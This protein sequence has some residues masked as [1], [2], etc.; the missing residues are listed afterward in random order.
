MKIIKKI[1]LTLLSVVF[2]V[3]IAAGAVLY[4]V[5]EFEKVKSEPNEDA[6]N[7][8][9][10]VE[11]DKYISEIF[12]PGSHDSA[13]A[14]ISFPFISRCQ[15]LSFSDQLKAGVRY[16]D[17]RLYVANKNGQSVLGFCHGFTQA[18]D[19]EHMFGGK[20]IFEECIEIF[21]K[22]VV[23]YPTE[24]II[25]NFKHEYGSEP[26]ST[27]QTLLWDEIFKGSNSK[28]WLLTD[29]IP[30]LDE[31]RGKIVLMR[32]FNDDLGLG[33]NAGLYADWH[34]Q[35]GYSNSSETY[36]KNERD[37][38]NLYVQDRYCYDSEEKWNAF[39]SMPSNLEKTDL[40]IN[41]SSTKGHASLG[42]PY[43]Y[44]KVLNELILNSNQNYVRGIYVLDFVNYELAKSIYERNFN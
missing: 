31:A 30:T 19:P 44:A 20:L 29:H 39:T 21:Y 17:M 43:K 5:P 10:N 33:V 36:E 14:S 27:V 9:G 32:R 28:Y 3:I 22:F 16:F 7:W 2:I 40:Y 35:G 41:F 4:V 11:G 25:M 24:T 34:D 8:M 37:N 18:K 23:N 15:G 26:L 6:L 1:F 12:I 38:F 13:T 42:H